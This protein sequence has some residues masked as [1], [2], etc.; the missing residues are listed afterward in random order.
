[1]TVNKTC[2]TCLYASLIRYSNNPRI[3]ECHDRPQPG[4]DL[5]PY[6]RMVGSQSCAKWKQD[7]KEKE[8]RQ[9]NANVEL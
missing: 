2:R 7:P 8:I 1:M 4:N 6:E 3:A 9:G 5:F